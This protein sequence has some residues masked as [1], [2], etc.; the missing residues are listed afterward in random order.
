MIG[1]ASKVCESLAPAAKGA[2]IQ[3]ELFKRFPTPLAVIDERGLTEI[4]E[5]ESQDQNAMPSAATAPKSAA[6]ASMKQTLLTSASLNQSKF[7]YI[8]CSKGIAAYFSYI[9]H[10]LINGFS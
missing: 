2:E 9:T 10:P 8:K 4:P 3:K 5:E 1:K 6:T 7:S